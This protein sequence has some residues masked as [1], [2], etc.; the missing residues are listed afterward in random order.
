MTVFQFEENNS[1]KSFIRRCNR[2]G[3][4]EVKRY[5]A[6]HRNKKIPDPQMLSIYLPLGGVLVTYDKAM[7]SMHRSDI[8]EKSPGIIVIEHSPKNLRTLT[9]SSAEAII[10]RFK[11]KV[12]DWYEV[13]WANSIV[14][15][16]E[17]T[18][19][20]CRKAQDEL[21]CDCHINLA[22]DDCADKIRSAL[23]ENAA[24]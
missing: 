3:A 10:Q 5:Q 18:V 9:Q 17:E 2:V 24:R 11:D 23:A 19:S 21:V 22:A 13:P 15:I 1:C 12:P 8:P 4:A 20:V 7:L 16:T 6:R 14:R